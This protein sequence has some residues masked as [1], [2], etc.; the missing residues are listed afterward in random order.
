M[1][2]IAFKHSRY[3]INCIAT[4]NTNS[5]CRAIA[6]IQY[7]LGVASYYCSVQI[8]FSDKRAQVLRVVV[9][10]VVM[11]LVDV[12]VRVRVP[13]GVRVPV[14]VRVPVVPRLPDTDVVRDLP[15]AST[16]SVQRRLT[17]SVR[18]TSDKASFMLQFFFFFFFFFSLLFLLQPSSN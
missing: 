5:S 4:Q 17:R 2:V 8:L 7:T 12:R 11:R 1:R 16:S 13:V 10:V 14:R 9:P 3:K 18:T 15:W 6:Y